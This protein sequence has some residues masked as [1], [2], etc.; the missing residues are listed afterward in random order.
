MDQKPGQQTA[1][2]GKTLDD[3]RRATATPCL[4]A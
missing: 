1:N 3:W 4:S 2:G